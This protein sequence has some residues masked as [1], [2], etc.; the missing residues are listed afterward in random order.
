MLVT[1][2][3]TGGAAVKRQI[4]GGT[5]DEVLDSIHDA[6]EACTLKFG[7]SVVK[8]FQ[9]SKNKPVH[10]RQ[11]KIHNICGKIVHSGD[12]WQPGVRPCLRKVCNAFGNFHALYSEYTNLLMSSAKTNILFRGGNKTADIDYLVK[13]AVIRERIASMTIHMLVGNAFLSES[14]VVKSSLFDRIEDDARWECEFDVGVEDHAYQKSI[15]LC[16]FDAAF[17]KT[18]LPDVVAPASLLLNVSRNGN[19][20]V[21]LGL[22]VN[23]VFEVGLEDKYLPILSFFLDILESLV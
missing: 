8:V 21:F 13:R 11:L 15:R 14:V 5:Y 3:M 1:I 10:R 19:V 7:L 18:L 17:C 4:S 6:V 23:T 16:N 12:I 2:S 20:N 9:L 22:P